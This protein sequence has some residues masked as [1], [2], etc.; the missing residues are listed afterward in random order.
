[1]NDLQKVELDLLKEFVRV[2][3]ENNLKYY[4][5]GGTLLGAVRHKGFI[6][7]D[8][9]IDVAMPRKDYNK[10][11][12]LKDEFPSYYFLQNYKTDPHYIYNYA[13]LRDSRTT[14]IENFYVCH[15]IN[16][17]VWIDI[18]PIDAVSK[19]KKPSKRFRHRFFYVWWN[20]YLM[21]LPGLFRKFHKKTFFKDLGLNIVALL[22]FLGNPFHLRNK[23]LDYYA[24]HR[25]Y[26]ESV[27]VANYMGNI[28]NKAAMPKEF[29]L[30][31]IEVEFEGNK[32]I[33]PKDYDGYLTW[34]YGDY[35]KLPP[36]EKRVGHHY[37]KGFDLNKGYEEY[38]KEHRI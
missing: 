20:V 18:F 13:K 1:M 36:E 34:V 2:C 25:N 19:K 3:N 33:G 23:W 4:L 35:M 26:D 38:S 15:K 17:G 9:D 22:T 29:F 27:L 30:D 14:Y 6:P 37:D 21:Y 5:I 8:D 7:W 11:M 24:S 31:G 12:K 16:H 32:Y 28:P 10:L